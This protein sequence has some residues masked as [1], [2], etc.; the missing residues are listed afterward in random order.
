MTVALQGARAVLRQ[1]DHWMPAKAADTRR[2]LVNADTRM[3]CAVMAPVI[4]AL[5][6][7]PRIGLAFTSSTRPNEAARVFADLGRDIK[8]VHPFRA[9]LSRF[10]LYLVADLLWTP[11]ARG[12]R[13]VQMSHSVAGKYG[14]TYDR[15]TQ[16]MR[17]WDRLLFINHRRARNY[18]AARAIETDAARVVG[19][20]KT[21]RLVNGMLERSAVLGELGLD[22]GRSTVLYA[23]TWTSHSSLQQ[24]GPD[25]VRILV[26]AGHQV[27]V[28]L[29]ANSWDPSRPLSSGA[30]GRQDWAGRLEQA[31]GRQGILASGS[32]ACPY[33]VAADVL[34][35]D[36]SS[37]G[38]EYLL[39][40]RPIVRVD[41]PVLIERTNI[42]PVYVEMLDRVSW[43]V[44]SAADLPVAL[45]RALAEPARHARARH[46]V[47][48]EMFYEP[49]GATARAV[50]E[51]YE[52]LELDLRPESAFPF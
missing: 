27:I 28:K 26:D 1:L 42:A 11:L 29:H 24:M 22:P 9:A 17:G 46:Q 3:E 33:L 12:A 52:V 39:L 13:R 6:R 49:G 10:D 41:M 25:I 35:T 51:L 19:M 14:D 50:R 40:D 31:L 48:C 8:T 43:T 18:L 45:E 32:D 5:A 2:V 23:P 21:D 7:D 37:V 38:F 44:R 47:A 4:E 20:P 36:H 16:P 15:P 34:V 30:S